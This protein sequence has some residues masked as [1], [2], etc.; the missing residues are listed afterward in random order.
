MGKVMRNIL[1]FRMTF[2][3]LVTVETASF[4]STARSSVAIYFFFFSQLKKKEKKKK[5]IVYFPYH[6]A[7]FTPP[8]CVCTVYFKNVRFKLSNNLN[9][10]RL[11]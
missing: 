11:V 8:L 10:T 6:S 1:F 9:Q 3:P 2:A 7:P 4:Y 5:S